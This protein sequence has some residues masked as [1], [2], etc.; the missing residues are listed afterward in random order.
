LNIKK[1]GNNNFCKAS[2]SKNDKKAN[3]IKIQNNKQKWMMKKQ[4]KD[5]I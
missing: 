5:E 3:L 1:L 4:H 2:I